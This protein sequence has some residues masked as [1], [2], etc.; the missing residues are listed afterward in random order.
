[1]SKCLCFIRDSP[2]KF[3]L[4]Y[5]FIFFLFHRIRIT[6]ALR[7]PQILTLG[8]IDCTKINEITA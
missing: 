3:I 2:E 1:M 6:V 4:Y 7:I 8:K 5:L